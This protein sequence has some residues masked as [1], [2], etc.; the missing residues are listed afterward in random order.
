M[1]VTNSS[2]IVLACA[3]A[4]HREQYNRDRIVSLACKRTLMNSLRH[5]AV[6]KSEN[7]KVISKR[8]LRETS[9]QLVSDCAAKWASCGL[10]LNY[11]SNIKPGSHNG[12]ITNITYC[13]TFA[14]LK[15]FIHLTTA[16]CTHC[17][18]NTNLQV[19]CIYCRD[20]L[21]FI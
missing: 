12:T 1:C 9:G 15:L 17:V 16:K 10:T 14:E 7:Q 20:A 8:P 3:C 5:P 19:P 2:G 18:V 6:I 21:I 11:N 4:S 13:E